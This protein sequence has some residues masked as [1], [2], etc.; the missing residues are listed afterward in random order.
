MTNENNITRLCASYCL[1]DS[2][3]IDELARIFRAE[4]LDPRFYDDVIHIE[5]ELDNFIGHAFFFT[6][7]CAVFWGLSPSQIQD[8]L[9]LAEPAA[10]MLVQQVVRDECFYRS[11]HEST[12]I[13][14]ED[15]IL[16]DSDDTVLKLS[17]S[18]GLSQSVKLTVFE[19]RIT[20]AIQKSKHLPDELAVKGKTS[21]SRQQLSRKVGAL[22]AERHSINLHN[23]LLDTPEF[24]WRRPSY[25]TY[26]HMASS[27]LDITTR[28]NILNQRLSIL[29]DLYEIL[30]D[31][32][33]HLHSSRLEWIIIL[34]IVSEVVLTLLKDVLKWL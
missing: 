28:T 3:K 9:E 17:W 27:Y 8:I 12:I 23:D 10:N 4:G 15:L 16:L 26:Y 22:Y 14:E 11:A 13:E 31:E 6:Y 20:L 24:F 1:A 33:K 32:L 5:Y 2:Y 34:L 30:S 21:L 29:H 7:G 19:D 18:Y 25:E